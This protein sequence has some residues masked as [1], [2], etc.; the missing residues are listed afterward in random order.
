MLPQWH[1]TGCG[2]PL[3]PNI[4]DT[5]CHLCLEKLRV[6]LTKELDSNGGLA[7]G[8]PLRAVFT[9]PRDRLPPSW[10]R[11]PVEAD[12]EEDDADGK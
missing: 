8:R 5:W 1:C 7:F 2:V 11:R 10:R 4:L 6:S 9:K 12:A 3:A